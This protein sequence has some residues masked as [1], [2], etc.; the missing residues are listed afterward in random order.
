MLSQSFGSSQLGQQWS[1]ELILLLIINL[2]FICKRMLKVVCC[3]AA[4]CGTVKTQT[5]K[6]KLNSLAVLISLINNI[7]RLMVDGSS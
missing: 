5:N 2:S 1:R 3:E 7:S 4:D 6:K